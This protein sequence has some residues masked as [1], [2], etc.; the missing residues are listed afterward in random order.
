[1]PVSFTLFELISYVLFALTLV[2]AARR[3]R[4]AVAYVLGGTLFGLTLEYANVASNIGYTYGRFLVMLG[5]IPVCIGVGWGMITYAA[6]LVSD[7]SGLPGWS[8]PALDALLALNIDLSMDAVA[9]RLGMW[10]WGWPSQAVGRHSQWFGVPFANFYGWLLVVAL[11]STFARLVERPQ[12]ADPR[13][14]AAWQLIAPL[15]AVFVSEAV[16]YPLLIVPR[17]LGWPFLLLWLGVLLLLGG[18][19]AFGWTRRRP[20]ASYPGYPAWLVPTFF[21]LYF[22]TWLILSA[23]YRDT[24]LL[25]LL[26]LLN[27][28]AGLAIHAPPLLRRRAPAPSG[29]NVTPV[30]E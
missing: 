12:P 28:A 9:Y 24:P 25:L 10:D 16:L 26:S 23:Y 7:A 1:M 29:S 11:Y 4:Q 20:P 6:R 2:H 5:P 13:R 18:V 15:L 22:L 8:R 17:R 14:R 27:A 19:F 3:G 30:G 21:H